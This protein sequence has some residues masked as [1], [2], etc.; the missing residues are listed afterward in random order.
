MSRT[1]TQSVLTTI[2][3][4]I[5]TILAWLSGYFFFCNLNPTIAFQTYVGKTA[6][7]KN[8]DSP[9]GSKYD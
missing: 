8:N 4:I 9:Y 5:A 2:A 3:V 7:T 6:F 1:K